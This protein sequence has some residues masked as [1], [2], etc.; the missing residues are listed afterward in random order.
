MSHFRILDV[1]SLS[2]HHVVVVVVVPSGRRTNPSHTKEEVS[3][4]VPCSIFRV[5]GV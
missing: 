3:P 2:P 5:R 1:S 4:S